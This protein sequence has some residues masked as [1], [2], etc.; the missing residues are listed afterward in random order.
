MPG[1]TLVINIS[2]ENFDKLGNLPQQITDLLEGAKGE[3]DAIRGGSASGPLAAVFSTLSTLAADAGHLPVLDTVVAP[4][5][6]LLT[7]LP[8]GMIADLRQASAKVDNFLRLLGPLKDAIENGGMEAVFG[9][10]LEKGLELAGNLIQAN[11]AIEG[12]QNELAEFFRLFNLMLGWRNKTPQPQEVAHLLSRALVGVPGDLLGAVRAALRTS[13]AP[14]QRLDLSGPPFDLWRQLPANQFTLWQGIEV[15][16]SAAAS[17]NWPALAAEL[18]AAGV[19]MTAAVAARDRAL[20]LA[21]DAVNSLRFPGFG[22]L[23]GAIRALPKIQPVKMKPIFDG[24][25]RQL[26]GMADELA[27]F[28]PGEAEAR[29]FG[30]KAAEFILGAV[31]D[32]PLG[33]LQQMLMHFQQ[34]LLAAIESMPFA[35]IAAEAR[36]GLDQVAGGIKS[37]DPQVV[38]QP[39]HDFFNGIESAIS[40]IAA[41]DVRQEIASLWNTVEGTVKGVADQVEALASTLE[42]ATGAIQEFMNTAQP[43]LAAISTHVTTVNSGLSAFDLAQPTEQVV[44]ALHKIRDTVSAIDVSLLPAP[45]VS[46]VKAAAE[47]L[48]AIDIAGAVNGPLEETL[49]TV[50]PTALLQAA[51]EALQP[52]VAQLQRFDPAKVGGDLDKPIDELLATLGRFGPEQLRGIIENELRPV[53]NAVTSIDFTDFFA[54]LTRAYADLV[55]KVDS[56]LDPEP[57]FKPL[58][59][60]FKPVVDVLDAVDPAKLTGLFGPHSDS[61]ADSISR[62]LRPS[63]AVAG[64]GGALREAFAPAAEAQEDLFGFRPGDMLI[65]LIDLHRKLMEAVEGLADSVLEPAVREL[66]ESLFGPLRDVH[67]EAVLETVRTALDEVCGLFDAISVSGR[68]AAAAEAYHGAVGK[69]SVAARLDLEA[70]DRAAALEVTALLPQLDPLRLVPAGGQAQALRDGCNRVTASLDLSALRGCF[71]AF[72]RQL[73]AVLPSFLTAPDLGASQL[74]EALRAMDPAPIRVEINE[75]FDAMGQKLLGL[76]AILIT[77]FEELALA[78]EERIMPLSLT[79]FVD[80]VQQVYD[81]VKKQVFA[82]SPAAFKADVRLLFD[83]VR[84]RLAAL[85]PSVLVAELNGLRDAVLQAIEDLVA[86][87]LP[88]PQPFNELLTRLAALKPSRLLTSLTVVLQPLSELVA[89]LDPEALFEPLI[90][91]IAKIRDDLPA[92][93]AELEAAFDEVLAAF[94]E[95]GVES[96]SVSV[97]VQA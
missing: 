11:P 44:A 42:G 96:V 55:A 59:D 28:G 8:G 92:V 70:G 45:A 1:A 87:L 49:A 31:E 37:L 16:F 4:V 34:R 85:D 25:R 95:G 66:R 61:M 57:I 65:P 41:N 80:F 74:K 47:A 94:P 67:P 73:Q 5:K 58:E 51:G 83:L 64:A 7:Q 19:Q 52:I 21:L 6:N 91:T 76:E 77:G 71:A 18:R 81:A 88:D 79:G 93:I 90:A 62:N 38:M 13:L 26:Q 12:I 30:R 60:L 14:L 46:A 53:R 36:K 24:L 68:M 72:S 97:S 54:P 40:A 22:E 3:L 33:R 48:R 82:L 2:A 27:L 75:L 23:T 9:K 10:A 63:T 43:A 78:F 32:S 39:V 84:R 86:G 50:D 20:S 56:L 69:I 17:V 15:R 35:A 29:A 89:T